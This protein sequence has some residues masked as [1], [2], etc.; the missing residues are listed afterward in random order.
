MLG[1]I[2]YHHRLPRAYSS[3][4]DFYPPFLL[5]EITL[6][7]SGLNTTTNAFKTLYMPYHLSINILVIIAGQLLT[8]CIS[9]E[10]YLVIFH[11]PL[12]PPTI[13]KLPLSR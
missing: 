9:I 6:S 8:I 7:L 4:K 10:T 11:R 12:C 5:L 13:A 3:P 1:P 2:P